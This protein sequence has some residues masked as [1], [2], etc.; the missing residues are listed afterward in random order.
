MVTDSVAAVEPATP[1]EG[2]SYGARL[3]LTL[4]LLGLYVLGHA[5][6]LPLVDPE[7]FLYAERP[8]LSSILILN[9]TPLITGFVLVELF[10]VTTLQGHRLRNDAAGRAKL[11]RA[12]LVLSFLM[13]AVQ[14]T[15]IAKWMAA[16]T[17]PAGMPFVT[18]PGPL[19]SILLVM[20]LTAV[21]AVL[22]LL[23]TLISEY[24]VGNGF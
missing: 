10:A 23:G 1:A 7:V 12:A 4:F 16:M 3:A 5:V 20:T 22:F 8:L 21:T 14:A 2:M 24:G 18:R 6:P 17:T 15:G 11:N 9:L 13:S 19:F